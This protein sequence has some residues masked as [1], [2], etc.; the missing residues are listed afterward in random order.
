[1]YQE[2]EKTVRKM[3]A[4]HQIAICEIDRPSAD[5][6]RPHSYASLDAFWTRQKYI[7]H[8]NLIAYFSYPEIG[9]SEETLH[10]MVF[11]TKELS[12]N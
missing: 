10:P 2:F 9:D 4:Y 3:G 6:K 8:P 5:P 12:L 11:W 1:M 7:K